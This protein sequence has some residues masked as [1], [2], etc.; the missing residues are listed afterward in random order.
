MQKMTETASRLLSYKAPVQ[1][2]RPAWRLFL[3]DLLSRRAKAVALIVA[4][5]LQD[6]EVVEAKARL[7]RQQSLSP[8]ADWSPGAVGS[9]FA[10]LALM[11]TYLDECF[12]GQG[13]DSQAQLYLRLVALG[14][15]RMSLTHP[16]LFGGA[17]GLAWTLSRASKGG[18][19]YQ[20]TLAH[21][22]QGL[23]DQVLEQS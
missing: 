18:S 11:Y 21:L 15:Q 16:G 2:D 14:T 4:E 10:G 7:A 3:S 13:W 22:H 6:P 1:K 9:G 12:P 20:K 5:R 19:R 8:S 23:C 17:G